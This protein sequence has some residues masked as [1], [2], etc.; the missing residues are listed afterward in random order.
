MMRHVP[1]HDEELY[2]N[3]IESAMEERKPP[4]KPRNS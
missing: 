4:G 1:R 2:H 3:I